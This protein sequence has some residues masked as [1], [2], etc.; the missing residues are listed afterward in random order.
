VIFLILI[1]VSLSVGAYWVA[2][3]YQ[4]KW[5]LWGQYI[6]FAILSSFCVLF[7]FLTICVSATTTPNVTPKI[8]RGVSPIA[9]EVYVTTTQVP[10]YSTDDDSEDTPVSRTIMRVAGKVISV[11]QSQVYI[12]TSDSLPASL[13]TVD[14]RSYHPLV[15][16]WGSTNTFGRQYYLTVPTGSVRLVS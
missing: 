11:D 8:Y 1:L 5:D 7:L 14:P 2:F 10:N 9:G 12:T 6:A 15:L 3:A 4:K 13:Y 16:P